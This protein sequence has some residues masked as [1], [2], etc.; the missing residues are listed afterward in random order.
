MNAEGGP[1]SVYYLSFV[2][3][4]R[5]ISYAASFGS[6]KIKLEMVN[7]IKP[8]LQRFDV[9]SMRENS[10]VQIIKNLGLEASLV[11]DPTLLYG[12]VLYEKIA[13]HGVIDENTLFSYI[14]HGKSH[15]A[16]QV[17]QYVENILKIDNK[18]S[19]S[20]SIEEWLGKICDSVF[21]VTNSF[22]CAVFSIIFHTPFA[23]VSVSGFDMGDRLFTLLNAVGL[24]NRYVQSTEEL[25]SINLTEIDWDD[26]DRRRQEYSDVSWDFLKKNLINGGNSDE[27]P[28]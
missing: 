11:C 20:N 12:S 21:V 19:I 1:T 27:I 8:F 14:L 26:V 6:S 13:K 22:H 24:S 18:D 4:V 2:G 17:I 25:K 7:Y 10:G 3:E 5:K 28:F 9:I 16:D 23:V 15:V